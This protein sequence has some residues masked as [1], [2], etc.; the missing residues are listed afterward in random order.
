MRFSI[1][2]PLFNQATDPGNP[3]GGGGG[4]NPN[5]TPNPA[6][7][8]AFREKV[9][10]ADGSFSQDWHAH[11]GDE[12]KDSA[13]S[14]S[15]FKSFPDLVKSHLH[16]Q[17]QLSQARPAIPDDKSSPEQVKAFR[18]YIGLPDDEK[19]WDIGKPEK[20]PDGVEWN[21][22]LAKAVSKWARDNHISPKAIPGLVEQ[23][24]TIMGE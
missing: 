5:P 4:D 7:V 24:N 23:F 13:A 15:R 10:Q 6:P 20:I 19:A 8:P 21:E 16:G 1:R 12:F 3:G 18:D 11:L 2:Y 22:G 9:F 14:L 17:R